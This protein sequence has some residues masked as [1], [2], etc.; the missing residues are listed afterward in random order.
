MKEKV[1][2]KLDVHEQ[3]A[4]QMLLALDNH[5]EVEGWTLS[6][7]DEGDV[8]L[9]FDDS[10]L[11]VVVERKTPSDY[12]GTLMGKEGTRLDEQIQKLADFDGPAYI[13]IEGNQEDF[14]SLTGTNIAPQSLVGSVAST[15][16][17]YL[18]GVRFCSDAD[19]LVDMAIRLARK[20]KEDPSAS[21]LQASTVEKDAGYVKRAFGALD[22][23]GPE[24]AD[25]LE[26]RYRT[27]AEALSADVEDLAEIDGIGEKRAKSIYRQ[28]HS[29]EQE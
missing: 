25:I 14:R 19:G 28:L 13:L 24:T 2:I 11:T 3:D 17:R 4:P 6:A 10:D 15:D 12:A 5:D 8:H 20:H 16:V 18:D 26:R 27:L 7:L 22:G 23:V 1:N 29:G 9:T 21:S